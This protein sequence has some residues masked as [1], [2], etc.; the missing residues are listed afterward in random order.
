MGLIKSLNESNSSL[1]D[2]TKKARCCDGYLNRDSN[3]IYAKRVKSLATR[4]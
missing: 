4:C 3:K 1:E 2:V